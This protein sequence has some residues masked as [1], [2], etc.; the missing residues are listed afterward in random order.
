MLSVMMTARVLGRKARTTEA[1]RFRLNVRD[2]L[3]HVQPEQRRG[4]ALQ[5]T[6]EP[7]TVTVMEAAGADLLR[8]SCTAQTFGQ[9]WWLICPKCGRRR[10]ALYWHGHRAA[11]WWRCRVCLKIKYTSSATH[12]T[13]QGDTERLKAGRSEHGEAWER[14]RAREW[15]RLTK[16]PRRLCE[17]AEGQRTR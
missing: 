15:G 13:P 17:D 14:A 2:V 8:L 1:E 3:P 9:R 5:I 7:L 16:M 10:A 11:G 6:P 4:A 12:R